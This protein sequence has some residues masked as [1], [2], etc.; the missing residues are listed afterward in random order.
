MALAPGACCYSCVFDGCGYCLGQQP[1]SHLTIRAVFTSRTLPFSSASA[2]ASLEVVSLHPILSIPLLVLLPIQIC[3]TFY[4]L[5]SPFVFSD[6][7]VSTLP[8]NIACSRLLIQYSNTTRLLLGSSS[9]LVSLL[10]DTNHS[11]TYLDPR[12]WR[13]SFHGRLPPFASVSHKFSVTVR[14]SWIYLTS[15]TPSGSLTKSPF[16]TIHRTP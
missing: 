14:S 9:Y 16:L 1:G 10:L 2:F 11:S 8:H 12:H 6:A 13:R 4:C 3:A 5:P 7:K 15:A